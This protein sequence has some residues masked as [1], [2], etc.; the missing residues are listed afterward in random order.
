MAVDLDAVERAIRESGDP[1][2]TAGGLA[3]D[4]DCS[5]RHALDLL[6]LLE[7]T[8]D[9]RS[10]KVG[11]RAV[12]WWHVD[13]VRDPPRSHERT[14]KERPTNSERT[15]RDQPA[16]DEGTDEEP[17]EGEGIE[18]TGAIE[19]AIEQAAEQWDDTPERIEQ[20]KQAARAALAAI[21]EQPMSKSDVLEEVQQRYPV[22][23]QSKR[24]WWRRNLSECDPS[25]LKQLAEYSNATKKWE[26]VG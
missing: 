4:L 14:T 15:T 16:H 25:P 2:V 22:D 3:D 5:S 24:T 8:G 23:G 13:R 7:R 11:A 19:Q 21:R 26:W 20:R 17:L 18:T 6:R 9:V 10:K 12:A 1:V